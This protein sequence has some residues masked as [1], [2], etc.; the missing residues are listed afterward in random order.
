MLFDKLCYYLTI[1]VTQVEGLMH[2]EESDLTGKGEYTGGTCKASDK[3]QGKQQERFF[4]KKEKLGLSIA[5]S[6]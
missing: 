2:T 5:L 4:I 6:L 3:L 1:Q